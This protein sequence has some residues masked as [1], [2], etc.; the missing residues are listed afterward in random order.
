M[1]NAGPGEVPGLRSNTVLPLEPVILTN[2]ALPL[3]VMTGS[4]KFPGE[5]LSVLALRD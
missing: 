3:M 2:G 4:L 5:R 1:K